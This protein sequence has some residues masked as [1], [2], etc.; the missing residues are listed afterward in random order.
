MAQQSDISRN[1]FSENFKKTGLLLV[2]LF[3][4]RI[5]H[6]FAIARFN[7]FYIIRRSDSQVF[8]LRD[9]CNSCYE[10]EEYSTHALNVTRAAERDSITVIISRTTA[11]S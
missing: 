9:I 8:V 4:V 10:L 2:M 1:S 6:S 5:Y 7:L 11:I 3:S